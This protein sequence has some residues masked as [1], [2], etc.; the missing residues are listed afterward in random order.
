MGRNKISKQDIQHYLDDVYTSDEAKRVFKA[1]EKG[2]ELLHKSIDKIWEESQD[3]PQISITQYKEDKKEASL[4]LQTIK[5]KKYRLSSYKYILS[6]AASIAILVVASVKVYEYHTQ[7]KG[8]Q[9]NYTEISTK[10]GE[11]KKV[12]LPDGSSVNLNTCSSIRFPNQFEK[13]ERKVELQGEAYFIITKNEKQPFIV[14]TELLDVKVLGTQFDVRTYKYDQFVTVSVES[15]KIQV[16]MPEA[17]VRLI[18]NEQLVINTLSEEYSKKK[19]NCSV[20][21]WREGIL[22]FDSTPIQDV[23]KELERYY[24][25]Q[26]T[27]APNQEFDN[28]ITGEHTNLNLEAVLKSIEFTSGIHYKYNNL[29]N[30]I[31]LY[32]H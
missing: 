13:H 28:L 23:A 6:I 29:T 3:Q 32:R 30:H 31:I 10:A 19:L 14:S 2:N 5:K 8:A 27:F 18:A 7:F 24:N 15:G 9:I 21:V 12:L 16:D 26:I 20:A 1:F 25:C 17:S 22:R 11:N 4:L